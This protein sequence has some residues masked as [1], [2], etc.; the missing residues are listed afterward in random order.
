MS[1]F[2]ITLVSNSSMNIF[3]ENKTSSFT[4]LLPEKISLKGEWCIGVAE[5]HYN[6][7]F[8][9]VNEQN[10]RIKLIVNNSRGFN[11]DD[12]S[13]ELSN[14]CDEVEATTH[15]VAVRCGYYHTVKDLIDTVNNQL[16]PYLHVD[17]SLLSIDRY[18]N[19]TL[20]HK[21]DV[22]SRVEH[23]Y[24][25]GRLA[26]QLGFDPNTDILQASISPHIGNVSFG[27]PDQMFIYTD[28][29]DPTF[30]GHEKAYVIK[31]I[32][33]EAKKYKFGD[34]CY[35]EYTHMHYMRMQKRDFDS[36]SVDI[37]DYTGEFMPFQ[38]GVLMIKL[39]FKN[40]N[41]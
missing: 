19:R 29:I 24:L 11:D 21:D 12:D 37:R 38:H 27:V 6:Y 5:V 7:N 25:D 28:I 9:N 3:P 18:S 17:E 30:I 22:Q 35:K 32:N 10:N 15:E 31:V 14:D 2:Y 33:T 1:D 34:A 20:V 39:H 40:Q 4:V 16:T 41:A 36:I 23:I 26:M 8:F 13:I